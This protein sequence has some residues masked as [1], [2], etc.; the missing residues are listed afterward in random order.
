MVNYAVAQPLDDNQSDDNQPDDDIAQM[1]V[2]PHHLVGRDDEC[3]APVG[4]GYGTVADVAVLSV[5]VG[6]QGAG[7]ARR[8]FVP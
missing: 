8:H 1:V 2:R 4:V 7:V 5:D 3:Q 6:V